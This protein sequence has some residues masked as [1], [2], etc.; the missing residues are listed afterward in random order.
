M[1]KYDFLIK[2]SMSV[3]GYFVHQCE[4][5]ILYNSLRQ[6]QRASF[7]LNKPVASGSPIAAQA[8]EKREV[9]VVETLIDPK[10]LVAKTS[11][12]D[13]RKVYHKYSADETI[14]KI[15]ETQKLVR[16]DKAS[17]YLYQA[18]LIA[19]YDRMKK[20]FKFPE[21]LYTKKDDKLNVSFTDAYPDL[22][23]ADW[24]EDEDCVVLSVIDVKLAQRMKL[25]HKVQ[26]TL[27][28][29]LLQDA[30]DEYNKGRAD[31]DK[32]NVK[33]NE[34]EGYLWNGGQDQ[35][36]AFPLKETAELLE[37][38]FAN[39]ITSVVE[40]VYDG[41]TKGKEASIKDNVTRCVGPKCEWCENCKQCLNEL[42]ASGST[43][44]I[45][46]LSAYAQEFARRS[47]AP[48]VISALKT[49][50]ADEDN[51]ALL[52]S[53]RSWN[54][55]LSDGTTI[56]TQAEAVPYGWNE[57]RQTKYRWKKRKSLTMPRW[58]DAAVILTAQKYAGDGRVYALGLMARTYNGEYKDSKKIFI[59]ADNSDKAYLDN[60]TAFVKTLHKYLLS[61][62]DYNKKVAFKDK[63][64]LQG[65]VMDS[66]ERINLEEVLFEVLESGLSMEIKEKTME[67][68][69]W[70][71]GERLVAE[72]S[73]QP[74][75]ES[76]YPLIVLSAEMRKLLS[77][78]V[79]VSYR[80]PEVLSA[81]DIW[82]DQDKRF[83]SDE[84]K[85]FFEYISN[86]MKSDAIHEFWKE[87]EDGDAKQDKDEILKKLKDHISKRLYAEAQIL[88][89]MQKE[90]RDQG[91]LVRDLPYFIMPGGVNYHT[92]ILRKWFFE[93]KLEN[94]LQYHQLRNT[95]LQGVDIAQETGDALKMTVLNV[96]N[97]TNEA[98]Y[99]ETRVMLESTDPDIVFRD[100]W[101]SAILA[102]EK[103]IEDLYKFDD[104]KNSSTFPKFGSDTVAVLNFISY[105]RLGGLLNISGL[106]K[107]RSFKEEDKGKTV[108]VVPRFTD[109]NSNKI[110]TQ[111]SRMDNGD[112]IELVDPANLEAVITPGF[113]KEKEKILS[114]SKPDDLDFT[115]SQR[116]A[117]R[118][119]YENRLTV[120]QGPPGTGKTDFIAR[121]VITLCR[122]Y[123]EV[124][125]REL[126]VLISA[127][128]HAA[129]ENVLFMI[130]RKTGS[131]Q[132][133]GLYK[134][135]RFDESDE[136]TRVGKVLLVGDG[137]RDVEDF[138]THMDE[139]DQQRPV[140]LGATSWACSN[141]RN[142][143]DLRDDDFAFDLIVIDEAS[144]VR[145][146]DA[147]LSLGMGDTDRTRYL[148]VGDGDQL[149][150]IIQ[151]QYGKDA[152]NRYEYGSVFDFYR[153]QIKDNDLMLAENFR[154]NEILLR[155]SAETIY[156]DA[157]SSF[158]GEIASRRLKYK[159][160]VSTSGDIIDHILDG[161][162]NDD[163][164]YW[165]LVFCR[166][167]GGTPVEQ[168]NAEVMLTSLLTEAIKD[169]VEYAPT[170]DEM[171]WRG[172]GKKDGVLGIV[173]PHHR[174]IEQLKDRIC[175]DT[176]MLRDSLYIG[177]VDKLQG[178]QREAVIVSY[179]VTDLESAVT[180][181]EF[182]F[183][184]NRLNVALTR[185][186]CKIITVFSEI[187][188]KAAPGMLDTED[189]DL[190]HGVE[191]VC[192]FSSFMQRTEPDTEIDHR[193]FTL[194]NEGCKGVVVDVYRKRIKL[195]A[196]N[197]GGSD[198]QI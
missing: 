20:W 46:Y 69:F 71:Q 42:K 77:L 130:D 51:K 190:M 79:P 134:A 67:I 194:Q 149:P 35:E 3:E 181:G 65:Y 152:G 40:D 44:V 178:Q 137:K 9:E 110:F 99:P 85:L 175:A 90:G 53:N 75:F 59:A 101:F 111:L 129:I 68:L 102:E 156:S 112:G 109:L 191:Y 26:V 61:V 119:L 60:I 147:M 84:Y 52:S 172:D 24:S 173:S 70:L 157:Y 141:L 50:V 97:T 6:S 49:Y 23:R 58:Q 25:A 189:E 167:S 145:V 80:L 39:V 57:I 125:N 47:N 161:Y 18:C 198:E 103:D 144:Q 76:E 120:L 151:G 128:S 15:R 64:K 136:L 55:I 72:S 115:T 45:P 170:D 31:K 188:T 28:V 118:H 133:I 180:E 1:A 127:N 10:Y 187:L 171:F 37:D 140:V 108:Y 179:G 74:M 138:F 5:N 122:C 164:E 163:D 89:K 4:R 32:L 66:Y 62:H 193:Q 83:E 34:S 33:V 113:E 186:K 104:Y 166:I 94:L 184:R 105:Q 135:S 96:V 139:N 41:I 124:N 73:D 11:V 162:S 168:N 17:R 100:E 155:Y 195:V 43:S 132:D 36:R 54:L 22:I 16:A 192:G 78:P 8:G 146:M 154:M 158:N 63:L 19:T 197:I 182:I 107:G 114:Y 165:P 123:H 183:N 148:L 81:M 169:N 87:D 13:G 21:A 30:I 142:I 150:A 126:R 82:I 121:A 27:Y 38:Y 116:K 98:G 174:H 176:G 143:A 185:A 196:D 93:V 48:D 12:E 95:R 160:D 14:E 117:F 91:Q 56:E 153:E 131:N 88:Y 106:V 177:T 86:V 2:P 29:R 159:D 92:E 7:G